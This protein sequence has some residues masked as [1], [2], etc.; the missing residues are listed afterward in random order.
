MTQTTKDITSVKV[1]KDSYECTVTADC[2]VFGFQE[3]V[4]KVLL[5]QRQTDPYKGYWLLPGGFI[6]SHQSAEEAMDNVL[7]NLTGIKNV[8]H[9]QVKCYTAVDRHPVK[10][11]MT[12]C[13]YGLVNPE[14]HPIIKRTHVDGVE[15]FKLDELPPLGFDN[16]QM[17]QDALER[18]KSNIEERLILD[19]LLPKQFTLTELQELYEALLDKK[20]D[21]RN[22]R[23]KIL[24]KE[25]LVTSG[26]K[27]TG[28]KGG[29][30]LYE[31]KRTKTNIK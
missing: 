30:L 8:H 13:F 23:K 26:E 15:W 24:Q 9:E 5:I 20:L 12:L 2:A 29:P 6:N 3:G 17:V 27:K 4:L 21:K 11:V 10:R 16:P 14:N 18:L 31:F 19:E 7:L 22:F 25:F 1:T 28:I